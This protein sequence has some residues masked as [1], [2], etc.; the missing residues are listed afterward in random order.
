MLLALRYFVFGLVA[1]AALVAVMSVLVQQRLMNPFGRTSRL[2]R[3]LSDPFVKPI[4]RRVLR[5][6]GNPQMAPW[7]LAGVALV[8]GILV[9]TAAD[10]MAAESSTLVAAAQGG[11]RSIAWLLTDWAFNLLM[12]ALLIRVI[13]SWIGMGAYHKLMRPFYLATEWML[14]PLRRILPPF[15]MMDFSP[16]VAWFALSIL[17]KMILGL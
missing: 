15:G 9:V 16:L 11:A 17:R 13:G 2:L 6:G 3:E 12:L 14:A 7:W 5:A 8:L 1:A 10:W 4:E